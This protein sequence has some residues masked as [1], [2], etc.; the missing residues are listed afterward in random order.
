MGW[1]ARDSYIIRH[2]PE[3]LIAKAKARAR[4]R[5]ERLDDMLIR[6]LEEYSAGAR[7]TDPGARPL[8]VINEGDPPP[9]F[10]E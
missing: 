3:G 4:E 2:V 10:K 6:T 8:P 7:A 9:D 1:K 5:G